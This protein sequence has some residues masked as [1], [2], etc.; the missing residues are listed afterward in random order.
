MPNKIAVPC[1]DNSSRNLVQI[2]ILGSV[3]DSVIDRLGGGYAV[4]RVASEDGHTEIDVGIRGIITTWQVGFAAKH[5]KRFPNVEIVSVFGTGW[6]NIDLELARARGI[7]VANT[8][9]DGTD[10][11][12]AD[13]AVGLLIALLRQIP[14]ADRFVRTGQWSR[15]KFPLTAHLGART[16]GIV[17]LG[18]IGAQIARRC[19]ALGMSISYCGRAP[20]EGISYR[21]YPDTVELAKNAD[22][23]FVSCRGG[24]E[25]NGF[26][27]SAALAALGSNGI[28]INVAQSRF[29]DEAAVLAALQSNSIAG[30][31]FDIFEGE[32][33]INQGFAMLDNVILSPHVGSMTREVIERRCELTAL[34]IRKHFSIGQG[35]N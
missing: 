30:A 32:P 25:L 5:L 4:H 34:A 29:I 22:T 7:A 9:L 15:A 18:Y 14:A 16:A 27:S 19:E 6:E 31:A 2:G 3:P 21:F 20:K 17:G 12:V 24:G 13:L 8:A 1:R 23:L 11:S 26:I 28:L 10:A 33:E 35:N